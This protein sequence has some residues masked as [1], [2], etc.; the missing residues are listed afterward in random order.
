M[1]KLKERGGAVLLEVLVSI[2]LLGLLMV[3][4][5]SGLM[6]CLRISSKSDDI[7]QARLAVSSAAETIM[8]TGINGVSHAVSLD[9]EGVDVENPVF[10]SGYWTMTLR[11]E[12]CPEVFAEISVRSS[13]LRTPE[14]SGG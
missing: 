12:K 5:S 4:I 11:S 13:D 1:K 9:L 8:A 7:M 10:T 14:V 6:T 2:A 3:P